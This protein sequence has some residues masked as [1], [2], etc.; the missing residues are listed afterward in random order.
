MKNN[1]CGI[2]L[3]MLLFNLAL[4]GFAFDYDLWHLFGKDVPWIVDVICGVFLG[5]F[6]VPVMIVIWLVK[7]FS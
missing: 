2:I 6:V 7:C 4:G 1:G 5:E 3:L